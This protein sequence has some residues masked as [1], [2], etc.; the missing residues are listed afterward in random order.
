MDINKDHQSDF[1]IDNYGI[2]LDIAKANYQFVNHKEALSASNRFIIWRHDVDQSLNRAVRLA[3]VEAARDISS[4]YFVNPHCNFYSLLEPDQHN[5]VGELIRLGH[6]IGL[7][8]DAHFYTINSEVQLDQ[9]VAKEARW[10]REWF[11]VEIT[12]FSFHNPDSFL[13][14]CEKDEYG[15]L[16]NCYSRKFK[17]Q[18]PYCSDSNGYWRYRRLHDVLTSATDYCLQVLTHPECW[19]EVSMPPRERFFRC[20][21]GRA[22]A[23]MRRWDDT[24][25]VNGRSNQ[26][27]FIPEFVFLK[28]KFG[29]KAELLDY[30]WMRGESESVFIDLWRLF[31]SQLLKFCRIW[32]CKSLRSS[33]SEA[34]AVIESDILKLQIHRVFATI[35]QKSWDEISGADDD[36]FF[37]WQNVCN[38][39]MHGLRTYAKGELDQGVIYIVQVMKRLSEFSSSHPVAYDE[40]CHAADTTLPIHRVNEGASLKWLSNNYVLLG[41]DHKVLQRFVES[42]LISVRSKL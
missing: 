5:K 34:K 36:E 20:V 41:L 42:Y 7:H 11:G 2:L 25:A 23:V 19:Q 28:K 10:L 9:L 38:H 26:G 15:G 30:R 39:L 3:T 21:D 33:F 31:E 29:R 24:L 6:G 17:K 13:S 12:T 27:D 8:F 1:T 40:S 37:A 18:I 32:F 4:T 14:T 16:I 22:A 35:Y